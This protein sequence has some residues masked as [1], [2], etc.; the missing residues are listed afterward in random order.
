[1][2]YNMENIIDIKEYPYWIALDSISGH[3]LT[4]KR[5]NMIVTECC[6]VSNTV[7]SSVFFMTDKDLA[8]KY[9]MS[10]Q[11]ITAIRESASRIPNYSFL[12]EDM[13]SQGYDIV[14]IIHQAFPASLKRNMKYN[15]PTL[16]YCKGNLSLLQK[17]CAAIVGARNAGTTALNFTETITKDIVLQNMPVVSG[18]AKG[19]D[20]QAFEA[21]MKY[22]GES[23]VVLPQGI[24]TFSGYRS[25]F[26]EIMSGQVLVLSTFYPTS[27]W[28][29]GLAMA[30]NSIIYGLADSIFVAE[31]NSKGGTWEGVMEGLKKGRTIYI[32]KPAS[33]ENTANSILIR[34]GCV[35]IL[36]Y[37]DILRKGMTTPSV[38]YMA[39]VP[40]ASLFAEP[41]EE[42]GKTNQE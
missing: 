27:P 38:E 13:T 28:S 18:Y 7:L 23:I 14:P 25:F 5:K 40:E 32:R 35:P 11:E 29:T 12:V 33:D 19:V 16:L 30:R 37:G 20:R 9:H 26:K 21:A 36:S 10:S 15:A 31:S 8:T 42:Y 24:L 34:K 41:Q 4:R 22:G 17:K 2:I 39:S 1:M 3:L 6:H